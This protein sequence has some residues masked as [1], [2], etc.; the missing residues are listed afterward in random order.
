MLPLSVVGLLLSI[1][2]WNAT[3]KKD[4]KTDAI[5]PATSNDTN[6]DVV[7]GSDVKTDNNETDNNET[8]NN[9]NDNNENDNNVTDK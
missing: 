3:V 9:K 1:R 8:D 5:A 2:I 6:Y 4:K 7:T